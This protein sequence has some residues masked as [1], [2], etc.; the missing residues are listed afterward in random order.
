LEHI[1]TLIPRQ[2][3]WRLVYDRCG[4]AQ[5]FPR[6]GLEQAEDAAHEVHEHYAECLTCKLEEQRARHVA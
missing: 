2:G 3:Y 5:E 6:L 4:H 1:G